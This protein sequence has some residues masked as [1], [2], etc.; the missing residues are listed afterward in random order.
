M[1][2]H[3]DTLLPIIQVPSILTKKSPRA[4]LPTVWVVA[5]FRVVREKQPPPA[6]RVYH[7][8]GRGM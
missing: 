5:P 6:G 1:S 7:A 3:D 8:I 4:I 2:L